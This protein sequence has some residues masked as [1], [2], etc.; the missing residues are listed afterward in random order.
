M[1]KPPI[2]VLMITLDEN[3]NP[4]GKYKFFGSKA[5]AGK[6]TSISSSSISEIVR[7]KI[8]HYIRTYNGKTVTFVRANSTK[9]EKEQHIQ[10]IKDYFL[11]KSVS[12]V[13]FML[14][15]DEYYIPTGKYEIFKSQAEAGEI[16]SIAQPS[17]SAIVNQRLGYYTATHKNGRTVT[18]I[19]G[20]STEKEKE[21]HIQRIKDH[22][23]HKSVIIIYLDKYYNPTGKY[24][25]FVSQTEAKE[26]T[27][28]PQY[29]ISGIVNQRPGY[30]IRTYNG[31]TIT[32]VRANATE[33]EKEKHIQRI[34][35]HFLHKSIIMIYLD[36]HYNPT[37]EY[38][39]FGNMAKA[40]KITDI[41]TSYISNIVNQKRNKY[42]ATHKNGRTVT[43]IRANATKEDIKSHIKRIKDAKQAT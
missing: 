17:I 31:K 28:T 32:F 20:N 35:D 27:N 43:F 9:K 37:G 13:Y 24:E 40:S 41:P 16:T 22:F 42:T 5:E 12:M 1:P 38:E 7:Q 4:I 3:Y 34:K 10:R 30:Y 8:G 39:I 6:I 23:L 25:F 26:V 33:E 2:P 11:H 19:R 18:F 36:M 15:L 29:S 14:Y 21:K